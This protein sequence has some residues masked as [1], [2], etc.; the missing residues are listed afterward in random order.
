LTNAFGLAGNNHQLIADEIAKRLSVDV[1]VPDLFQ[2]AAPFPAEKMLRYTPEEP[3]T[4]MPFI[5]KLWF[6]WVV[7]TNFSSALK[8]RAGALDGTVNGFFTAL[9][10]EKTYEKIGAIGYC[11]GGGAAIRLAAT[12]WIDSVV[13]AHPSSHSAAEV[14]AIR[15]PAAWICPEDDNRMSVAAKIEYE[16]LLTRRKESN[17]NPVEYEFKTYDGTVHGFACR[18]NLENP[19]VKLAFTGALDQT[20]AWFGKTL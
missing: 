19:K 9:K 11:L 2:G 14:Q 12:E 3:G 15:V 17:N 5:A 6:W 8:A 7:L 4:P 13:I 20:V 10:A 1:Y 16:A 18:P